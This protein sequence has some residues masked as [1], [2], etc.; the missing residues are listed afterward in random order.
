MIIAFTFK[1]LFDVAESIFNQA[2][3]GRGFIS[4]YKVLLLGHFLQGGDKDNALLLPF[5]EPHV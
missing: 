1:L 2:A 3:S 4:P 5:I